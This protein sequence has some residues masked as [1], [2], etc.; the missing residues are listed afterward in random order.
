MEVCVCKEGR[1]GRKM[2]TG[3]SGRKEWK[4]E[5]EGRSGQE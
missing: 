1:K 2:W 3:M 4:G 5:K